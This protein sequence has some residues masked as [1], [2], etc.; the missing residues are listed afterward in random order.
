MLHARAATSY[1]EEESEE[2]VSVTA[3]A[4]ASVLTPL[5]L[6]WVRTA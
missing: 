5:L 1:F 3:E 2:T 6:K 4:G